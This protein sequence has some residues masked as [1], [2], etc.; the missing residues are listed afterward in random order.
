V[1]PRI[2]IILLA[3]LG[4][5]AG[6]WQWHRA[7]PPP[8]VA[9]SPTLLPFVRVAGVEAATSDQVLR[10]RAELLDPTPL[11]FPTERNYGRQSR[12]TGSLRQPGQVFGNFE[13]K[14]SAGEQNMAAFRGEDA[15]V[16]EKLSDLLAHGSEAH[17]AGIGQ[18]DRQRST[19]PIRAA[20]VEVRDLKTGNLIISQPLNGIL[21]PRP[22]FAPVEFLVT[23]SSA[24]LVGEP[25]LTSGS[26]GE[27]VDNFFRDYLV[28]SY[29]LGERLR[30]GR[31]RVVVGA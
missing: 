25:V 9:A 10:E 17:F 23:V 19:L 22:D 12:Q 15:P 31:Y 30:P 21:P 3:A 5:A 13:P 6:L 27:D 20:F 16:P 24:G 14:L 4:G 29:R 26:E 28:Q 1:K 2:W 18:I 11:F 7:L 8:N